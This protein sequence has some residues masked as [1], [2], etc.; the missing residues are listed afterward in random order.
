MVF[1]TFRRFLAYVGYKVTYVSNFTDV[2][3]KII[4]RAHE[5]NDDPIRLAA[6][7]IDEF[8]KENSP[9]LRFGENLPEEYKILTDNR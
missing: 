4:K 2:D 7:Y 5:E 3:D 8:F 6:R 1:D 9:F